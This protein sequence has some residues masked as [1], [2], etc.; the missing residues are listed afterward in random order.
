MS[1]KKKQSQLYRREARK[2]FGEYQEE[3][4]QRMKGINIILR[5]KPKL[6]PKKLWRFGANIFIDVD[7]IEKPF[8]ISNKTL[9]T[10]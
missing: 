4:K 7:N 2:V 6:C 10:E 8:K 9:S 1:N 5:Q 3:L